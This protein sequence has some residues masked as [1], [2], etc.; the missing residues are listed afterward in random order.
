VRLSLCAPEEKLAEA[1][2]R[3]RAILK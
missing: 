2:E 1:L 3:I